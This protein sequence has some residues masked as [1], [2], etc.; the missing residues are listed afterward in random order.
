MNRTEELKYQSRNVR[1]TCKHTS[2]TTVHGFL[3]RFQTVTRAVLSI[4]DTCSY[5]AV[6]VERFR[7][8]ELKGGWSYRK[9]CSAF[10]D[11]Y[12]PNPGG[13]HLTSKESK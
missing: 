7:P 3:R 10:P 5:R 8:P 2:V 9:L 11:V 1:H 4:C 13:Y 6:S 12:Q